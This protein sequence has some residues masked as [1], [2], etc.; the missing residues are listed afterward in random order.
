MWRVGSSTMMRRAGLLCCGKEAR[1]LTLS[2]IVLTVLTCRSKMAGYAAKESVICFLLHTF[3]N[4]ETRDGG[5]V[6]LGGLA[7][8]NVRSLM[9]LWGGVVLVWG[10][11]VNGTCPVPTWSH[12]IVSASSGDDACM[13]G[14]CVGVVSSC[15]DAARPC[16]LSMIFRSS[17]A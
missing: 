13:G 7:T 8:P 5:R 6:W 12:L 17:S 3:A 9:G 4:I 14:C 11:S 1:I 10:A 15:L 16:R 2:D